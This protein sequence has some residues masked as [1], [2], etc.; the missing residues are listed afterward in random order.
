MDSNSVHDTITVSD[1][2]NDPGDG[3]EAISIE[4]LNDS[5]SEKE[6]VR[7]VGSALVRLELD[8]ACCSEKLVNMNLLMMHVSSRESDFEAFASEKADTLVVS[9]AKALEFDILSGIF[10]SEVRE[11][12]SFIDRIGT[13]INST[14]EIISSHKHLGDAFLVLEE[15]LHDAQESVKQSQ[16]Q[17]SEL[18]M[19]STKFQKMLS[20]INQEGTSDEYKEV[21][22]SGDA[23]FFNPMSKLKIEAS[24]QHR[25]I[26]KMLEKSLAREL[27]LENELKECM[28]SLDEMNQDLYSSQQRVVSAE[29]ETIAVYAHFLEADNASA[30]LMGI[31]KEL[32]GKLQLCQ[33]KINSALHREDELN[34]RLQT[35][36]QAVKKM[37][38]KEADMQELSE[39]NR[40]EALALK[41]KVASLEEKLKASESEL[42]NG[43][44]SLD[45]KSGQHEIEEL[46][47]KIS[48]AE[49]RTQKAEAESK[50]LAESNEKLNEE[51]ESLKNNGVSVEKVE[52]LEKQIR[53][54][55]IQLQEAM[56][57]EEASQEKQTLLYSSI[58]DMEI[59]IE[60]L[61]SKVSEADARADG[62]ED[63]C[64]LLSE[65]HA[66]L[67]EELSFLRGKMETLETS[68]QQAEETK[69]EAAKDI[70]IRSKVITDMVMQLAVERE[71]LQKQLH[72]IFNLGLYKS[73]VTATESWR[74][75]SINALLLKVN[76][77]LLMMENRALVDKSHLANKVSS[78]STTCEGEETEKGIPLS[79]H[80]G[81][82]SPENVLE[83][84]CKLKSEDLDFKLESVR[85]ID[86]GRLSVKYVFSASFI[87]LIAVLAL[88]FLQPGNCPF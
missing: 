27:E 32:S 20:S 61:K 77:S 69:R 72:Y 56:A 29:E 49:S 17:V 4:T 13:E 87:V 35:C 37:E 43:N 7:E 64:I 2:D 28:Q 3:I 57:S 83:N 82:K 11:M 60:K 47:D 48:E 59:L 67:N 38:E 80:G 84:E 44:T 39:N 81:L 34:A 68:L 21:S 78:N 1:I 8:I 9:D 58:N 45:G 15:T 10:D 79:V 75:H 14:Y 74:S 26:L 12:D 62:A 66:E 24:E 25:H 71:R 36:M 73:F 46:E 19:Q 23:D 41:E 65:R 6:V 85:T 54:K 50:L 42:V 52:L 31:S 51:L 63:K 86:A 55:D 70:S 40:L 76:L 22:I 53:E 18:M 88:C 5:S 16:E 30:V 33:L